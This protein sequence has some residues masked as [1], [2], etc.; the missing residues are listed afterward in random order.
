[1]ISYRELDLGLQRLADR[2][3]TQAK[4]FFERESKNSSATFQYYFAVSKLGEL[5]DKIIK[6]DNKITKY[7]KFGIESGELKK[8]NLY[9]NSQITYELQLIKNTFEKV[10]KFSG[11]T[12]GI[13]FTNELLQINQAKNRMINFKKSYL[14]F[15]MMYTTKINLLHAID[16]Y[17][18]SKFFHFFIPKSIKKIEEILNRKNANI[19]H[20]NH[21][22]LIQLYKAYHTYQFSMNDQEI[23][24]QLEKNIIL[25][26]HSFSLQNTYVSLL[27]QCNGELSF[28]KISLL[29]LIFTEQKFINLCDITESLA[30]HHLLEACLES[31]ENIIINE[32]EFWGSIMQIASALD[33]NVNDEK[34]ELLKALFEFAFDNYPIPHNYFKDQFSKYLKKIAHQYI[35]SNEE[36][37]I[38][39]VNINV[40]LIIYLFN[41]D[42]IFIHQITDMAYETGVAI[43]KEKFI[44]LINKILQNR[45]SH[46]N[47]LM[48]FNFAL[49]LSSNSVNHLF[50]LI[51]AHPKD[52]ETIKY[53]MSDVIMKEYQLKYPEKPIDDVINDFITK[54]NDVEFPLPASELKELQDK[55]LQI[56]S[57]GEKL[58]VSGI[59]FRKRIKQLPRHS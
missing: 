1:M 19:L 20:L 57:L 54:S 33:K 7:W 5:L 21:Y 42:N 12:E 3:Y 40:N 52:F 9:S 37:D 18:E 11:A 17:A 35:E 23:F 4:I 32:H 38:Q 56:K 36:I 25:F 58:L 43:G 47:I 46:E 15:Q 27:K 34:N 45:F 8:N 48:T 22:Q 24:K 41:I 59:R 30:S 16:V 13:G 44:I 39:L 53:E 2:Q 6:Y 55:Y 29:Y 31:L 28:Q 51:D 26:H 50:R 14:K 49:Q 10:K